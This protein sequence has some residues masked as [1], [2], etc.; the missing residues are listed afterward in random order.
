MAVELLCSQR[1]IKRANEHTST[2]DF[3]VVASCHDRGHEHVASS[4]RPC[5]RR[6]YFRRH[7]ENHGW[8]RHLLIP[9]MYSACRFA[10]ALSAC[11]FAHSIALVALHIHLALV[12]LHIMVCAHVA[13]GS[14]HFYCMHQPIV[15]LFLWLCL[16]L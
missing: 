7:R 1:A 11:R 14:N 10:H 2:G 15:Q 12:A 8:L 6:E 5:R 13:Y 9:Y 4:S 3:F 16:L